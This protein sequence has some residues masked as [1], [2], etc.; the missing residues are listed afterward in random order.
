M[1][2]RF[3]IRGPPFRSAPW[4]RHGED[5][6]S[7]R[8]LAGR[9]V[10]LALAALGSLPLWLGPMAEQ[11]SAGHPSTIDTVLGISPLTHLAV[12]YGNDLLR[13]AWLYQHSNLAGLQADYPDSISLVWAYAGAGILL[14]GV[15]LQVWRRE[16]AARNDPFLE[17]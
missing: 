16:A 17:K 14:G 15:A 7:A 1:G 2:F 13:N 11:L 4:L 3:L 8:D 5:G 12:A 9:S 6:R 10:T